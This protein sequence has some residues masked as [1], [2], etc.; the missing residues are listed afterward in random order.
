M[1]RDPHTHTRSSY[2]TENQSSKSPE[3]SL[4]L[5]EIDKVEKSALPVAVLTF[6]HLKFFLP[7][8][9]VKFST[10]YRNQNH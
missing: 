6:Y 2:Q 4:I 1:K 9:R 10:P 5:D 3:S 8:N 7:F